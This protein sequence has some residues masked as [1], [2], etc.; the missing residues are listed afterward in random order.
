MN[1][2]PPETEAA[3]GFDPHKIRG[4]A[5]VKRSSDDRIVAGV[6]SGLARYLNIDPVI[7]R[8]ILVALT[9]VG[10]AGVILYLAA[11]LFL[12]A[13]NEDKSVASQ[14]FKLDKNE[15][16]V[17]VV[18]LIVAGVLA[19]T[20]GTGVLGGD[21]NAPFP[22]F[23]LI[24]LAAVY[25]WVIKPSQRRKQRGTENFAA[26]PPVDGETPT[27][28][29]VIEPKTP[30]SPV[31]TLVTLSAA[32]IALGCVALYADAHEALPWTTYAVTALG[33]I[34]AGLLV[35]AFWGNA[36]ALIPIGGL[37]AIA[38]AISAMLPSPR[39]GHDVFP[40]DSSTVASRYKLGIGQLDLN[41]DDVAD[42]ATLAGRTIKV[43]VGVGST[44]IVVPQGLNV[45]VNADL[46]AGDI[47]VFDR[48]VSG[49]HNEIHYRAYDAL[50]SKVTLD[51]SQTFGDI[52][53]V[54]Q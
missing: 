12:P 7:L 48:R 47:R 45:E 6:C 15:E 51:I 8:V 23:G 42:Q 33:V 10:F 38:L 50:A 43:D 39:I 1:D 4:I 11:W 9:F 21:W 5:D 24:V 34:G 17:R 3:P 31:L 2:S 25:F 26:A 32:L 40:Q 36:G 18:G 14:W 20:S 54:Q 28:Q 29:L 41:L 16:Q 22:W 30:W 13:D 49:T 27:Q 53:V 19:I 46:N 37:L 35:G 44:R 52:E